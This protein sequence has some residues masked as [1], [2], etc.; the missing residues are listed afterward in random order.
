MRALK[1]NELIKAFVAKFHDDSEHVS[2]CDDQDALDDLFVHVMDIAGTQ[3][4]N[5]QD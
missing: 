2:D 3:N 5:N 4:G 1:Q